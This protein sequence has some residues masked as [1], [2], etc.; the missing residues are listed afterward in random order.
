LFEP[1]GMSHSTQLWCGGPRRRR[2]AS[3]SR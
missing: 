3:A 2:T 1:L